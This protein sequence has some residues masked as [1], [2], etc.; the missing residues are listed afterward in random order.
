MNAIFRAMPRIAN[1]VLVTM[2]FFVIF[3]IIGVQNFM[4]ALRVCNDAT[5]NVRKDC[6]GLFNLTL[7]NC[8]WQPTDLKVQNCIENIGAGV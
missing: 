4:G 1:V 6:V 2:L 8:A 3:A 7:D 5:I